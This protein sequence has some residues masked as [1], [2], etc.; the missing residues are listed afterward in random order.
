MG[1][2]AAG[3]LLAVKSLVRKGA[4]IC[5]TRDGRLYSALRAAANFPEIVRWLIVERFVAN[6]KMLARVQYGKPAPVVLI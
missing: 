3:R 2:C 6:P 5:Y 4:K 1:A